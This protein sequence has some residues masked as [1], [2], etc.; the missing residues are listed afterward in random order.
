MEVECEVRSI[1]G[2]SQSDLL[3]HGYFFIRSFPSVG[4]CAISKH[5][6]LYSVFC[7]INHPLY[8]HRYSFETLLDAYLALYDYNG[9]DELCGNWIE[10]HEN[11]KVTI[12]LNYKPEY[13]KT[14]FS[15]AA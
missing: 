11:E 8:S 4:V 7:G 14:Y 2:K 5:G 10:K 13:T 12:N 9:D 1:G 3:S 6:F 15:K